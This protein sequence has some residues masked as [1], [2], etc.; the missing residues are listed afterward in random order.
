VQYINVAF[1][2][3]VEQQAV[4]FGMKPSS[5]FRG[6]MWWW[7]SGRNMPLHKRFEYIDNEKAAWL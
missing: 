3:P 5:C 6:A 1:V 7:R 2:H 4:C